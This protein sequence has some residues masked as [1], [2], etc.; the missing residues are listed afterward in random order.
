MLGCNCF[1]GENTLAY[2]PGAWVMYL[3]KFFRI[4]MKKKNCINPNCQIWSLSN[5]YNEKYV[6]HWN[7]FTE[8][9]FCWKLS[10]LARADR[11]WETDWDTVSTGELAEFSTKSVFGELILMESILFIELIWQTPNL[12]IPV[13][14]PMRLFYPVNNMAV[15][16]NRWPILLSKILLF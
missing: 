14:M 9:T 1:S 16:G 12:T 3:R 13:Y 6:F 5:E 2:L 15:S 8:H 7:E 11:D 10:K 4:G